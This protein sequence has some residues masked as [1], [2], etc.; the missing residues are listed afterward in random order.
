MPMAVEPLRYL[1]NS[2]KKIFEWKLG[3]S[4]IELASNAWHP[5]PRVVAWRNPAPEYLRLVSD[6][7]WP[8][9][10]RQAL[11]ADGCDEAVKVLRPFK[12]PT[13]GIF[14]DLEVL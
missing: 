1:L 14:G 3:P 2:A 8:L 11:L 7:V 10:F 13:E 5:I 9:Q 4:A 12:Q 6:P